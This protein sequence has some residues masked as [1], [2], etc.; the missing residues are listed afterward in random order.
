M[1]RFFTTLLC[2]TTLFAMVG[3]SSSSDS[4]DTGSTNNAQPT[5]KIT[6][7][8][9]LAT[10]YI[11]DTFS[12][13]F[14]DFTVNSAESAESYESIVPA[15]G[16]KLVITELTIQN[17][18]SQ[19]IPMFSTDFMIAW[20]DGDDDFA[21][22]VNYYDES[23][24]ATDMFDEEYELVIN[25]K[26]TGLYIFEVPEDEQDFILMFEEYF[27]NGEEGDLFGVYFTAK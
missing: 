9:G 18:S 7:E 5:E 23:I 14:F 2:A 20:S 4:S 16:N 22:P 15:E 10:G 27:D 13:A 11:V 21:L 26:R 12:N 25:E 8:D 6:A 3:C 19:T 17:T 1:K 24:T